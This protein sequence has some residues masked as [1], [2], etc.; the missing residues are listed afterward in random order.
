MYAYVDE[1]G[2]TG[3]ELFDSEQPVFVTAAMMTKTNFDIVWKDPL[4]AIAGRVGASA[5]HANELGISRIEEIADDLLRVIKKAD[6]RFFVSRLEKSYLAAAKVFDTY[7]D[8]GENVAVPWQ[9][10]WIR[11]LRLTLMFKLA[12]YVLDEEIA[13]IVWDCVTAKTETKSKEFFVDG[14]KAILA[15]APSLPD[16]RAREI[17]TEA[18][19]WAIANPEN[20]STHI[21]DKVSRNAH[22]PNFVAFSNLMDGLHKASKI[23]NR[24]VREIVHDRQNQFEKTIIQWHE[25]YSRP[26]LA[27]ENP[28]HWPGEKEPITLSKTPGSK[29][30]IDTEE[31]SPGLQVIDV[32]LWL[33]KRVITDKDIGPRGGRLLNRVY[34]RG[35]QNDLS[36]DGVGT[37]VEE[38]LAEIWNAPISEEQARRGAELA[39]KERENRMAALKAHMATKAGETELIVDGG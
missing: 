34:Q 14:A 28:M 35:W 2:N 5:L 37:A 3:N 30:R 33:F 31:N 23:W 9:A 32:V 8:A 22:S 38:Q 15:R 25:V 19:Q 36:F 7:F 18:M 39:A 4:K 20:F 10:Y 11:P 13:R 16:A 1:T 17:V 29:L 26:E 6:A 21:R 24:P 12:T 27:N